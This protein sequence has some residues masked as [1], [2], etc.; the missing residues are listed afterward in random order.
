MVSKTAKKS[1]YDLMDENNSYQKTK[2]FMHKQQWPYSLKKSYAEKVAWAFYEHP[3]ISG[4]AY[5]AVGGL[6][7]ITLFVF[8]RSIGINVPAV[9]ASSLEDKSIQV[10]HKALG[11]IG[12]TAVKDENGKPYTKMRVIQQFGYPVISKEV[13]QKIQHI[14]NPTEKNATVRHAIMTGE[15]GAYG[16]YS[17]AGT[18]IKACV[19]RNV[20]TMRLFARAT[21]ARCAPGAANGLMGI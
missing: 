21:G 2:D 5:V 6:D 20:D 19:S 3:D 17:I 1:V 11:V 18:P 9:S 15:T 4:N 10:V 13:A 16:G 12:L 7:S 14:Q 8:L